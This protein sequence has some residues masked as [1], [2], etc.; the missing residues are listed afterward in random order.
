[1]KRICKVLASM[2]MH[3]AVLVKPRLFFPTVCGEVTTEAGT[4][5]EPRGTA[6]SFSTKARRGRRKAGQPRRREAAT[7]GDGG[8]RGRERARGNGETARRRPAERRLCHGTGG[9]PGVYAGRRGVAC[10]ETCDQMLS[11]VVVVELG[12]SRA[13]RFD[14]FPP[15]KWSEACGVPARPSLTSGQ[16]CWGGPGAGGR[17]PRSLQ[18]RRTEN[19]FCFPRCSFLTWDSEVLGKIPSF[20]RLVQPSIQ[21]SIANH[22]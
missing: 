6:A 1:M 13:S 19:D 10:K 12:A 18:G 4:R 2:D 9:F 16:A 15:A 22:H 8:G 11:F 17:H 21:Q 3:N 14:F 5:R 7:E 20:F